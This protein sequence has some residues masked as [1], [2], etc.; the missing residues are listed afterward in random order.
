MHN[1][2]EQRSFQVFV[3]VLKFQTN[4][5]EVHGAILEV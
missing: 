4:R 2:A 5:I 3:T 1:T